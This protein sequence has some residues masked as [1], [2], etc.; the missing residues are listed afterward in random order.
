MDSIGR[1]IKK[2]GY[3]VSIIGH[4]DSIGTASDNLELSNSRANTVK[5]IF[6]GIGLNENQFIDVT[7]NNPVES[8]KT[9]IGRAENR[10]VEILLYKK[11]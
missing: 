1:K 4:T 6:V 2:I 10:R 5:Q 11:H 7:G 9:E 8:N 3:S